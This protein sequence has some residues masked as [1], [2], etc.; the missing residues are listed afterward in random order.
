MLTNDVQ[1]D[2]RYP[3]TLL[4]SYE[5]PD[6][7]AIERGEVHILGAYPNGTKR[8]NVPT[9]ITPAGTVY[10]GVVSEVDEDGS[11]DLNLDSGEALSFSGGDNGIMI[12]ELR[13]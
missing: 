11:F 12:E 8:Y 1:P 9:I 6:H 2:R 3:I 7:G 13:Q 10:E 4:R 5:H